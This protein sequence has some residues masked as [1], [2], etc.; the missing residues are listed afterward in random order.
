[1]LPEELGQSAV[2]D[3][4]LRVPSVQAPGSGCPTETGSG[5]DAAKCPIETTVTQFGFLSY[6]F[7]HKVDGR[8]FPLSASERACPCVG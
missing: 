3:S 5:R 8:C 6:R 7:T 1:M 4:V 2:L